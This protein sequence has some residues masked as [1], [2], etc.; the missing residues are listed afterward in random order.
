VRRDDTKEGSLSQSTR[1]SGEVLA[2]SLGSATGRSGR[3][4][5]GSRRLTIGHMS[6]RGRRRAAA[7]AGFAGAFVWVVG[8][9]LSAEA[10]AVLPSDASF[11]WEGALGGAL[12]LLLV[13]V[14]AASAEGRALRVGGLAISLATSATGVALM[15][16]ASGNLGETAPGWIVPA[17]E[18]CLV[19][20]LAWMALT[21]YRG[22]DSRSLGKAVFSAGLLIGGTL[23]IGLV[24][25]VFPYTHTNS[26]VPIDGLIALLFI[27]CVPVWLVTVGIR[28]WS[29]AT[30]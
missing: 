19:T 17:S 7:V 8:L 11:F 6:W 30:A 15:L 29:G 9:L 21:S 13:P 25:L 16:G 4:E 1:H 12:G 2:L 5:R 24:V 20:L 26:T 10:G 14:A 27:A 22:R 3:V 23:L 28:L 18:A